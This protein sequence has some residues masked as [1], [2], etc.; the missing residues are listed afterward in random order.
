[1]GTKANSADEWIELYNNTPS[2]IDLTGWTIT[3]SHGTTTH[4]LTFSTSTDTITTI[5][6]QGFFLLE[7]SDDKS[8]DIPAD[9][10]FTGALDNN[11]EKLELRNASGTLID[12]VDCSLGWFTGTASPDYI[13][14]ERISSTTTG[15]TL[16]NWANNNLITRNGLDAGSPPNK[17][18]GTPK[19]ENSVSKSQTEITQQNL[20]ELF[21]QFDKITLTYYGNPYITSGLKVPENKTLSIEPGVI[22]QF[23]EGYQN[24]EM[25]SLIIEGVL[26]A[27]SSQEKIVFTSAYDENY[28]G[29]GL[30]NS[31][32]ERRWRGIRF[33]PTSQD[34]ELENILIRYAGCSFDQEYSRGVVVEDTLIKLKNSVIE[35]STTGL[36]LKN[37][38]SEIENLIIQDSGSY[39]SIEISGGSPIIKDSIFKNNLSGII[40]KEGSRAE[41]IGNY[42]EGIEYGEGAI[43]VISSYPVLKDNTGQNNT[44]N[45]IYLFGSIA[46]DW[47]LYPNNDFPYVILQLEIVSSS[48]LTINPGVVVKFEP[49]N[50]W[51]GNDDN[52]IVKGKIE[53]IGSPTEKII[54]TS[55]DDD[56]YGGDTK[57]DGATTS[58]SYWNRIHFTPSSSASIFENLFIGYGGRS[59]CAYPQRGVV[60]VE[61]NI[62]NFEN[63]HFKDNGP[64]D[65][66]LFLENS[67][68][69]VRNSIFENSW[70]AINIVGQDQ[71]VFENN[72]FQNCNC[73]VMRD[74]QC[75][76][77]ISSLP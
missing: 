39:A 28:G 54:F 5:S 35:D 61:N 65:Y 37:S 50:F 20:S 63:V 51:S 52:L 58:I 59:C 10:F 77:P 40:I 4:S 64:A 73:Y 15:A 70:I 62:V 36:Y 55:I 18:N 69:T 32:W 17:I 2:T 75:I 19:A 71:N 43:S 53:A 12:L 68:S 56:D 34:S 42:F 24:Y 8:T 7:R 45:G 25:G 1:M 41:I 46:E 21:E 6:A 49:Y 11:G 27:T 31:P 47:T 74:N 60:Y 3:W 16:T 72:A 48:T 30:G 22:L 9:Q 57:N 67:T 44:L 66:T 13:S 76:S 23:R 26:L 29:E 33:H 38:N 14:M